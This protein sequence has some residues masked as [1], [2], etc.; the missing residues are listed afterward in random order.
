MK[1]ELQQCSKASVKHTF[2]TFVRTQ[3]LLFAFEGAATRLEAPTL[4]HVGT[5]HAYMHKYILYIHLC[6]SS[7]G[8]MTS[9]PSLIQGTEFI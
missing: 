1:E 9:F 3:T 4:T 6:R 8:I 2:F 5:P 7:S